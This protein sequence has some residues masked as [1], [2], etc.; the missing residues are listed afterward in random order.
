MLRL[1]RRPTRAALFH[2]GFGV[3]D[4]NHIIGGRIYS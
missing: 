3:F 4:L 2:L 1:A